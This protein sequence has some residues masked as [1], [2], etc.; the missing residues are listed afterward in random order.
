MHPADE[1]NAIPASPNVKMDRNIA[2]LTLVFG[3]TL[4]QPLSAYRLLSSASLTDFFGFADFK[5][6]IGYSDARCQDQP[7]ELISPELPIGKICRLHV[8]RAA[9]KW[10]DSRNHINFFCLVLFKLCLSGSKNR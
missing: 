6:F 5:A 3:R 9:V 10:K 7:R 4:W 2:V 1:I 8:L